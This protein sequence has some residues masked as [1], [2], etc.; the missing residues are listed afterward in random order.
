MENNMEQ[1]AAL[2]V[3]CQFEQS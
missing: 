1:C 2:H 3:T